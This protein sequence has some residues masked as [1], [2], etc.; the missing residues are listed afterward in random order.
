MTE[1]LRQSGSWFEFCI[2]AWGEEGVIHFERKLEGE[3]YK[4]NRR[5]EGVINWS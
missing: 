2:L 3:S 4:V 1:A 5:L